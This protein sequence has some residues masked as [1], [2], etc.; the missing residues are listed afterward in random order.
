MKSN[1]FTILA[2]L[3]LAI[4]FAFSCQKK[5][6]EPVFPIDTEIAGTYKGVLDISLAGAPLA[7]DLPKN[8]NIEKASDKAVNLT[9]SDFVFSGLDL[10]TIRIENCSLS[11]A[12]GAYTFTGTQTLEVAGGVGTCEVETEGSIAGS[13]AVIRLDIAVALLDNATVNVTF[14]G[15]RLTG[16]ESSSAE[17]LSF[18]FDPATP[19]NQ[20]VSEQ[21]VVN[22]NGTIS[23]KVSEE[24][25]AEQLSALVP[26]ITVSDKAT[27]MPGSG[28]STDFSNNN[29]VIYTVIA[30]DG[31]VKTYK[32]AVSGKNKVLAYDFENWSYDSSLYPEEDMIHQTEGWATCNNAVA[33]I[34]KMGALGGIT[35]DGE[36]PVRPTEECMTGSKA[37]LIESVDTQGGTM[38]GQK[39]PKVTAGTIFLGSF[40]A[41]AAMKDPMKTTSFGTLF[42][43][44][45]LAVNGY[46][47]Y[48]PGS[49]F[50]DENG[51]LLA[52][53]QDECSIGAVLYEV[54]EENETLDGSNLY[55]SD[56]ICAKGY[57]TSMGAEAYTWFSV[58]LDYSKEYD[59]S[60]T[61][62]L[63]V[64]F[65]SSKDG[66]IYR[67]AVG[68]RMLVDNVQIVCE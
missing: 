55:T 30:E 40:N 8:I 51:E 17:I 47:Q 18:V 33:L 54:A 2:A 62:K 35:Y 12:D 37:V 53:T 27:V 1:K 48:T 36:Y 57:F 41:F 32:A 20:I 29:I 14:E 26:T 10:G 49:E 60:K 34:K 44:K 64:V 13:H 28:Q 23:F 67:A 9:L 42:T 52:D 15:D 22:E 3:V 58:K 5:N 39:V 4:P 21:P 38:M 45:P 56:K 6:P 7:E 16:S 24:A 19:A 11:Q 66:N 68:S 25:T 43:E 61:Y 63:A 31:T 59:P 65:A 50:Y 46:F